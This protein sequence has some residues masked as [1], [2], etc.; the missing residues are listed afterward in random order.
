[1]CVTSLDSANS[2]SAT[3]KSLMTTSIIISD[4][5]DNNNN[6]VNLISITQS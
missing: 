4:D 2:R 1:M 3:V 5:D 6:I